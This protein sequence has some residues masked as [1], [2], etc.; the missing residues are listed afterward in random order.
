MTEGEIE[1]E[2]SNCVLMDQGQS[3]CRE[4]NGGSVAPKAGS[5][6]KKAWCFLGNSGI[7]R[8]QEV[9]SGGGGH[10][11]WGHNGDDRGCLIGG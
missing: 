11:S 6:R 5:L 10:R 1:K 4:L 8:I 3:E 7:G 2:S 9:Q